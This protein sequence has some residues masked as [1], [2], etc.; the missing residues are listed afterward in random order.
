MTTAKTVVFVH[1]A[2]M[3]PISWDPFKSR[4][5]AAGYQ[6]VVPTWPY[7]DRPIAELRANPPKELGSLTVGAVVDHYEKIIRD[8]PQPPLI[9]G[10]SFGGLYVQML[11]DRGVGAAG[12]AIDPGPI[13]GIIPDPVSLGSALPLILRF[14]GWSK[15]YMLPFEAFSKNFANSL[16]ENR[17]RAEYDKHVIPTSGR[18][19]YQAATGLGTSVDP[20]RR[21]QPLLLI[22]GEKDRT[23]APPLVKAA[24]RKQ[25]KSPARTDFKE[26][27][28]RSHYLVAEPGW[29]E[30]ADYVIDWATKL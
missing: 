12:V 3:T 7:L 19:F 1:G 20:K 30:V 26:F 13:G 9:V 8:L 22:S 16:P 15:P 27:P 11:L 21:S 17:K 6:V 5:E 24:Y 29:E 2:W 18:I 14:G 28:G 23:A 4:F 10:H 25:S